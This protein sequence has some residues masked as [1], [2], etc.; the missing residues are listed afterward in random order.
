MKTKIKDKIIYVDPYPSPIR[1][2]KWEVS[3]DGKT[4]YITATNR[5]FAYLKAKRKYPKAKH[6][7]V[8]RRMEPTRRW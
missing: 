8:V 3:V 1:Y 2:Y 4:I 5:L 7:K 6:I